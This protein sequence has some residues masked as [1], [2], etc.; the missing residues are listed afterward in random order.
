MT[1]NDTVLQPGARFGPFQLIE[2]A[3]HGGMRDVYEAEDTRDHRLV[4]LKLI[5]REFSD[6]AILRARTHY[7]ADTPEQQINPHL[8]PIQ[9]CGDVDGWCYVALR[10]IDGTSLRT[11]LADHGR[12]NPPRAVA[13]V[14]QIAAALDAAHARGIT[15]HDVKPENILITED[16]FAY[17]LDFGIGDAISDLTTTETRTAIGTYN[18][19]APEWFTDDEV[20]DPADVYALACVLSECLTGFPPYL[21]D[22]VEQLVAQQLAER[23]PPPS[24]L[25]PERI[26]TALDSVVTKGMAADPAERYSS[27]GN[28]AVAAHNALTQ[29]NQHQE[30]AADR[31]SDATVQPSP[32]GS[33]N[34]GAG[35]LE[36]SQRGLRSSPHHTPPW[37]WVPPRSDVGSGRTGLSTASM[38]DRRFLTNQPRDKQKRWTIIGVVAILAVV[39]IV[40]AGFLISSSPRPSQSA[41]P[42]RQPS[43]QTVLPFDDLNFRL[44]PGGVAVDNSGTVYVTNQGMYGRVL[45]LTPGSR[46]PTVQ[47]FRGLYE[48][49][50]VAVDGAASVYVTDF[51]NRVVMLAAGSSSQIELPFSGL[52]YPEG[53]AV[54]SQGSVYVADRGNNRVVKLPAGLSAQVVLPFAGLNNP[55]GVAVDNRGNVYVTD[56]DNSR[57]VRLD[58]GSNDQ[59]VLPLP[60]RSSPWGVAVD[61]VGTVFLTERDTNMVVKWSPGSSA[62][63]VLPFTDLNTPLSVAVDKAGNVYVADRG[64]D[65]VLQLAP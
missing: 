38:L 8:V 51:N 46:T 6:D 17:L 10:M 65:S 37:S 59:T 57:I 39:A 7:N 63:T 18:Y 40:V 19:M 33:W 20:S 43:K 9:E 34:R 36:A 24:Q 54:D 50:G 62:P 16:Y 56:T 32:S 21:A 48:P 49:Q 31:S 35:G 23:P 13:I 14:E 5:S 15:Y 47:Q 4:F 58:A 11:L 55:D 28:L 3:D 60:L 61:S 27:A 2:L 52:N 1:A 25:W 41:L 12:L 22:S 53:V 44:S 30:A 29:A 26:S 64:D 42:S 45:A